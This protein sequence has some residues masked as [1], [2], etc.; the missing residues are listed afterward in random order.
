MTGSGMP[1]SQSK[2]PL[3]NVITSILRSESN[4]F[5]NR[6]RRRLFLDLEQKFDG[7]VVEYNLE[8][9]IMAPRIA[10]NA[11]FG[12]TWSAVLAGVFASLLVQILLTI[13]GFG[14]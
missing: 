3:P 14:I 5:L 1:K 9:F 7:Y 13:L 11:F 8:E 4:Q 10:P 2:A 12:W 6:H